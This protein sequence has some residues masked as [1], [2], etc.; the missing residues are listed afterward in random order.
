LANTQHDILIEKYIDEYPFQETGF[1]IID[2][3]TGNSVSTPELE[4]MLKDVDL[5]RKMYRIFFPL[6]SNRKKF[7]KSDFENWRIYNRK[8]HFQLTGDDPIVLK[9]FV[10]SAV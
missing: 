7:R 5:F 8:N 6:L 2:K 4:K 10:T 1:D 3:S 9:E